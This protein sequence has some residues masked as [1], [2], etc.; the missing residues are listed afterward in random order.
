MEGDNL[1]I[2]E[3]KELT[4]SFGGLV[5]VDNV[6][7][8]VEKGEL[9]AVIGPNGAGKTTFFNVIAGRLPP[10][11][12]EIWFKGENITHLPPYVITKKGIGRSFQITNIF[13]KLTV[14]ENVRL[15]AQ[16][17]EVT[18]NFW[19]DVTYLDDINRRVTEILERLKL[20]D[21]KDIRASNLPHGL[22]RHLEIGIAL[23]SHP[24]L[25]LLDEPTAGMTE[26]ETEGM[27]ELINEISKGLT[28]VLVEH[29]MKFVMS[30]SKNI[31]VLHDGRVLAEGPPN[32]IRNNEEVQRVYLGKQK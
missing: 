22:Q 13:P 28:I 12:G 24:E 14:F 31:T 2:I 21:Y 5:A 32:E 15:A 25:L 17:M 23:A 8:Q 19:K 29:D 26:E 11:K 1:N 18:F 20:I 16:A 9:R 7:F 10:T 4:K 27:M 3:T 6:N 30:V